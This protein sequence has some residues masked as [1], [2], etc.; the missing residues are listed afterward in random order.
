MTYTITQRDG[1]VE[2]SFSAPTAE[3]V[4]ELAKR[5]EHYEAM[6]AS[7][8]P[9]DYVALSHELEAAIY[10]RNE[11]IERLQADN[12]ALRNQVNLEQMIAQNLR[13]ENVLLMQMAP[14]QEQEAAPNVMLA[15]KTLLEKL[16]EIF[17]S[18]EYLTVFRMAATHGFHYNGPNCAEAMSAL[19]VALK[20]PVY[21]PPAIPLMRGALRSLHHG[22]RGH[23]RMEFQ[24]LSL[25]EMHAA[26]KEWEA[27]VKW[28]GAQK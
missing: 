26:D 16:D 1:N 5:F 3:D 28:L 9:V 14:R 2:C 4:V 6:A 10:S 15:A 13:A 20:Q 22:P 18:S 27:L 8:D 21:N 17:G 12:V 23:T 19:A 11:E 7:T 25:E 24:F